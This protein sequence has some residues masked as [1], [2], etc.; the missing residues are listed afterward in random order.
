MYMKIIFHY[1]YVALCTYVW[2]KYNEYH[3]LGLYRYRANTTIFGGIGI[4]KVCYTST[5]SVVSVL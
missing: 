2:D 5:N 4:G 3:S 1:T